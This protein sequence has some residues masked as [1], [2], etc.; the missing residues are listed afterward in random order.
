MHTHPVDE[1]QQC[2]LILSDIEDL[3]PSVRLVLQ[4]LH[5]TDGLTTSQLAEETGLAERTI[6]YAL[7]RLDDQGVIESRYLLSDPQ[8]CKYELTLDAQHLEDALNQ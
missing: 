8:T 5:R 6:R 3:P 1:Q 7:T 4:S 2:E